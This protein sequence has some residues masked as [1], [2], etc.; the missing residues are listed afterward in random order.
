MFGLKLKDTFQFNIKNHVTVETK[1]IS[2]K[3]KSIIIQIVLK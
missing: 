3:H 1:R 2:N